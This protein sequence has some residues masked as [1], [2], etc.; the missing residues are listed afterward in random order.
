[1]ILFDNKIKIKWEQ[2]NF[3]IIKIKKIQNSIINKSNVE[4]WNEKKIDFKKGKK[5]LT[6][7]NMPNSRTSCEVVITP[8]K[9][10]WIKQ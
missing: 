9:I 6:L 8:Y 4:G 3:I 10:N 2:D 5:N 1:M 7:V